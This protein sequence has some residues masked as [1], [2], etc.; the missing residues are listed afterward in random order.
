MRLQHCER[1]LIRQNRMRIARIIAIKIT[2][3]KAIVKYIY[4]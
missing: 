2:S 4:R 3:N 1:S